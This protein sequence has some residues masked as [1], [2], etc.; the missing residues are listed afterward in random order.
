LVSPGGSTADQ[1]ARDAGGTALIV[2][3]EAGQTVDLGTIGMVGPVGTP[4]PGGGTITGLFTDK[5]SAPLSGWLWLAAVTGKKDTGEDSY[6]VVT[7]YVEL[8]ETGAFTFGDVPPGDYLIIG[9]VIIRDDLYATVTI[10]NQDTKLI[11]PFSPAR[12][13]MV[14]LVDQYDPSAAADQY[15]DYIQIGATGGLLSGSHEFMTITPGVAIDLGTIQVD[16]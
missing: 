9:F 16:Y 13:P 4:S 8:S 1:I 6:E 5:A 15:Q 14:A 2:E 11:F 7:P 10:S 3:V 12:G